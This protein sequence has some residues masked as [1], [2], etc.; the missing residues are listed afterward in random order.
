LAI[1]DWQKT[2]PL[3]AKAAQEVLPAADPGRALIGPYKPDPLALL[4]LA[5]TDPALWLL[6]RHLA[7]LCPNSGDASARAKRLAAALDMLGG[8]WGLADLGP[9]VAALIEPD[10]WVASAQGKA[11]FV[12][13]LPDPDPQGDASIDQCLADLLLRGAEERSALK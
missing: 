13:L 2:D 3:R 9:P 5:E 8:W 1:R 10:R 7:S 11:A 4:A 6:D 12:R